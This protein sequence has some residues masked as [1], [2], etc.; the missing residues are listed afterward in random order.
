MKKTR[1]EGIIEK[2]WGYEEIFV[3]NDRYCG[4]R[5]LFNKGGR[6]SMH[7]HIDKLETWNVLSG[8]LN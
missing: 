2:G 1:L 5:L 3:T 4:K 6:F 8:R 7:F